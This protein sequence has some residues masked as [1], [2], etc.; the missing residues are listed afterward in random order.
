MKYEIGDRVLIRD[1]LDIGC[2]NYSNEDGSQSLTVVRSM[3]PLF[4]EV[5]TIVGV[6]ERGSGLEH[7]YKVLHDSIDIDPEQY[8]WTDEMFAGYAD[9]EKPFAVPALAALL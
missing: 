3:T 4:G 6:F 2:E 8:G 5:V 9:S 1:D 7:A